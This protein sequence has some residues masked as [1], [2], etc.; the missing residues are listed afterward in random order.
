LVRLGETD[1][2]IYLAENIR[3]RTGAGG[4]P[5]LTVNSTMMIAL[6]ARVLAGH[7]EVNQVRIEVRGEDLSPEATQLRGEIVRDALV[8][9]GIDPQRLRVVGLGKGKNR[10]ELVIESRQERKRVPAV[11]AAPPGEED[12]APEA[13][14]PADGTPEQEAP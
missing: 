14:A 3:F 4:R 12:A 9:Q 5:S 1:G 2:K 6:V 11:P 7:V 13:A 10:V 8:K